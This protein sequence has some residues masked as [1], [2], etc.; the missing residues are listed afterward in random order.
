M[1]PRGDRLNG[2]AA[3]NK[4]LPPKAPVE[5]R[6]VLDRAV[7]LCKGRW[8]GEFGRLPEVFHKKRAPPRAALVYNAAGPQGEP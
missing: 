7:R 8:G 3:G 1:P 6:R 2:S 4:G 5:V